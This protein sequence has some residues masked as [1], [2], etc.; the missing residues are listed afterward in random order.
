MERNANFF[1]VTELLSC[2]AVVHVMNLLFF[3]KPK[4]GWYHV[5]IPTSSIKSFKFFRKDERQKVIEDVK[6]A[7]KRAKSA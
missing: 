5:L 4:R 1:E 2:V 3:C 6:P 7:I